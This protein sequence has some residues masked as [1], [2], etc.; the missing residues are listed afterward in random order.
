MFLLLAVE[1]VM[2]PFSIFLINETTPLFFF[3]SL[4]LRNQKDVKTKARK[5]LIFT[6]NFWPA[7]ATSLLLLCLEKKTVSQ[8][9]GLFFVDTHL[10][11]KVSQ[12]KNVTKE[13]QRS[14]YKLSFNKKWKKKNFIWI[15]HNNQ[16]MQD[17]FKS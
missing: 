2:S 11:L 5:R 12:S 16:W 1:N 3:L 4:I 15:S 8:H 9:R 10:R 17:N 7:E 6:D 13:M 14:I